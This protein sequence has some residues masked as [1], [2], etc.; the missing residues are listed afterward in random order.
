M[1]KHN[2]SAQGNSLLI[3]RVVTEGDVLPYSLSLKQPSVTLSND[4]IKFYDSGNY[5][6]TMRFQD[7]EEIAVEIPSDLLDAKDKILALIAALSPT[8]TEQPIV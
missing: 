8:I 2:I 6:K 5:K 7:F 4:V 1:A 3:E